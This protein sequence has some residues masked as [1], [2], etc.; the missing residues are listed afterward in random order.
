MQ[1]KNW[2][3]PSAADEAKVKSI[4]SR[5]AQSMSQA[6]VQSLVAQARSETK[7]TLAKDATAKKDQR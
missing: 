4:K 3:E 6:E 5:L 1:V 7:V 2:S